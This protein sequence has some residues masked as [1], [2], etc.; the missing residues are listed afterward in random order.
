MLVSGFEFDLK[1]GRR[2]LVRNPGEED[3]PTLLDYLRTT[4]GETHFLMRYPEEC[5]GISPDAEKHFIEG[6]NSSDIDAMLLCFVEGRLA[7]NCQISCG[8]RIKTRHRASLAIALLREFW[9]LG[10]GRRLMNELFRIAYENENVLQLELEFIE[11]NDRARALY[12]SLGFEVTGIKPDAIRL[13]DG[14]LLDEYCMMT[15]LK[16]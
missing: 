4:A 8:K 15:K 7:G 14:T 3:V 13:K 2:A 6:V 11:G 5:T 16:R 12:E 9:G 1:D 10:I